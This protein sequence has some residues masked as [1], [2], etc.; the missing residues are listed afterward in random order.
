MC[1]PCSC[2]NYA[3]LLWMEIVIAEDI[4][5]TRKRDELIDKKIGSVIRM[6]RLK[7]GMTQSELGKALGVTFQQIQKYENGTNAVA[8]T[9]IPDLCRILEISPNGLFGVSAKMD[10]EVLQLGTWG[11]KTALKL[12]QLLP[13]GRY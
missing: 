12:Q 4:A 8:A 11:I 10:G 3:S 2:I 9:R 7:W 13:G 5:M 6:Q 1:L